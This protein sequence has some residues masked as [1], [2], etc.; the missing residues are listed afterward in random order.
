[1]TEAALIPHE[2]GVDEANFA[3]TS[4]IETPTYLP[5]VKSDEDL[6]V[7]LEHSD[8]LDDGAPIIAPANK[9]HHIR[10]QSKFEDLST[11]I[12]QLVRG[13]PILYREPV[14]LYRYRRPQVL[15]SYGLRGDK[16]DS[17]EFYELLEEEH[18]DEA[19][20][21]L[22]TFIK[23]FVECQMERLLELRNIDIPER[24]QDTLQS[25]TNAWTSDEVDEQWGE[26]FAE[27]VT[28]AQRSPNAG[29]LGPT[30][31]ITASSDEN[32]IDRMT[33]ANQAIV[34]LCRESNAGYFGNPVYPYLHA[35]VDY[36]VLKPSSEND[37]R[38][39]D[40]I[41]QEIKDRL[42]E[43]AYTAVGEGGVSYRGIALTLSNLENAWESNYSHR[44][45]RFVDDIVTIGR[46]FDL[47][48]IVP[49]SGWF[50]LRLTDQGV[51]AFSSLLNGNESYQQRGADGGLPPKVKYGK[52]AFYDAAVHPGI[53]DAFEVLSDNE[54]A[55][56]PVAGLP[57][58]PP[59]FD[60]EADGWE[61]GVGDPE[62]YRQD[63]AKPRRLLHAQEA[64]EIREEKRRGTANPARLYLRKS[65]NPYF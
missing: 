53:D 30:P 20:D 60:E 21:M 1:M 37:L 14:E 44:V 46:Q 56:H 18:F 25:A 32:T 47:P 4:F 63:F 19:L 64:R 12:H 59:E 33:G 54:G 22:P 3:G 2:T 9:W 61:D 31:V 6:E 38:V 13:R 11:Q 41:R 58:E 57:N 52:T 36:S 24:Y 42:D 49:R 15:V 48:T 55:V 28:N 43:A 23:P 51:Q 26:Y 39:V 62:D 29:V 35:Y 16:G 65:E 7:I 50:G 5:E 40:A 17:R 34:E 10:S 8:A 45:L 27:I